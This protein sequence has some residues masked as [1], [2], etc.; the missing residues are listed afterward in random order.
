MATTITAIPMTGPVLSSQVAPA[1]MVLS[2]LDRWAASHTEIVRSSRVIER[3]RLL[4]RSAPV[5]RSTMVKAK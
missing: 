4:V 1:V 2:P 3:P 5:L